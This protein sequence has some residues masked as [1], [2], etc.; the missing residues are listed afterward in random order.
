M[1]FFLL[2]IVVVFA[3]CA[4]KPPSEAELRSVKQER[5]YKKLSGESKLT[6]TRDSGFIGSACSIGLLINDEI[7]AGLDPS[8]RFQTSLPPG[9]YKIGVS[10]DKNSSAICSGWISKNR[11]FVIKAQSEKKLRIFIDPNGIPDIFPE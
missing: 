1:N 11:E 7:V 8:E 5:I 9:E 4:T 2:L 3:S 10:S 6:V